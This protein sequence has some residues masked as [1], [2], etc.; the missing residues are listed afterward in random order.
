MSLADHSAPGSNA[1]FSFQFERAL[2]YLAQSSAGSLVGI[3]T[4]DDVAVRESDGTQILEQDKHSIQK[5][6][7]PF[8]DRSKDLW[9]TLK[10]W[11]E[12]LDSG[13]VVAGTTLFMMVTNKTLPLCIARKIG[14]AQSE[15]EIN[16]CIVAL[17]PS[18]LFLLP[19]CQRCCVH[20]A[21]QLVQNRI[22]VARAPFR[23]L[24]MTDRFLM[25]LL[26]GGFVRRIEQSAAGDQRSKVGTGRWFH[27]SLNNG[28]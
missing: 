18:G 20:P 16:A 7:E 28:L 9:N 11:V 8:G 10:I 3:E 23:Q 25:E 1:G 15:E 2:L 21:E 26:T 22:G 24:E 6:A 14:S 12:A 17:D 5:D 13:G 4:D 19:P 27:D